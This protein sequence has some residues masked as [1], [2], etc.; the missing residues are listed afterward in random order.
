LV[1]LNRRERLLA[2]VSDAALR[3]AVTG[4]ANQRLFD[5][6]LARAVQR[7]VRH[8]VPISVMTVS[9]VDFTMVNDTL[10]YPV[11]NEL[12]RSVGERIRAD[13]RPDDTVARMGGDEFAILV[14]DRSDVAAQLAS[15]FARSFDEPLEIKDHLLNVHLSIGVASAE[16]HLAVSRPKPGDLLKQAHAARYSAQQASSTDVRIFTPDMDARLGKYPA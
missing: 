4:L 15:R 12:L 16:S 2:A 9:V 5:E 1:M 6:Q 13:L 3:D 11:G 10:G 14:E 8:A 7:Y